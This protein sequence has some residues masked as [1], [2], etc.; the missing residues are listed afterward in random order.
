MR[1]TRLKFLQA[2]NLGRHC[3]L[4]KASTGF[5][6]VVD[7]AC[8]RSDYPAFRRQRTKPRSWSESA[9]QYFVPE[10]VWCF[11]QSNRFKNFDGK[12]RNR[13]LAVNIRRRNFASGRLSFILADFLLDPLSFFPSF[14]EPSLSSDSALSLVELLS[15]STSFTLCLYPSSPL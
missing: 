9:D 5:S 7:S 14:S 10:L 11:N 6:S 2:E 12:R 13:T 3:M 15:Y 1:M 4:D 8:D